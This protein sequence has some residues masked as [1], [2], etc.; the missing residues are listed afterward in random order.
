[1][2]LK[3]EWKNKS[4]IYKINIGNKCYI[5]SSVNLYERLQQHRSHLR[6]KKH[7][8]VF[9]QRCYNKYKEESFSIE[10]LEYC[11]N[12]I[13]ILREKELCYINLY[14]SDF[15]STTPIEYTH[16]KEMKE[17]ISSTLKQKYLMERVKNGFKR[18][19]NIGWNSIH[20]FRRR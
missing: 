13:S 20:C 3:T 1:M 8:S 2:K 14:T 11:E 18:N 12:N 7:H 9:M 10:I 15:N 19:K 5:G 16:S 4:G 6:S 17:K